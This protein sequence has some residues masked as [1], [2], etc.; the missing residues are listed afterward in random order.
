MRRR[1]ST[2]AALVL[3][4]A[5]QGLCSL[6]FVWDIA[7]GVIGLRREPLSWQARELIEIGAGVGL[8]LGVLLGAA[9]ADPHPAAQPRDRRA[10]CA[11]SRAR[12]PSCSS[13]ASP[14][15]G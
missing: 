4:V 15:G 9:A 10:G 7:A 8:I 13:S 3:V 5:V 2:T 6:F 11:R 12:S 1:L 14:N